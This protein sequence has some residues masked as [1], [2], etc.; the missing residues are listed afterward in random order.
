MRF[1]SEIDKAVVCHVVGELGD[2]ECCA[3]ITM[4]GSYF[5]SNTQ[6]CY[7][8]ASMATFHFSRIYLG[9]V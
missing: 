2:Q 5:L 3:W 1:G 6:I 8:S 4:C 9:G 7:D